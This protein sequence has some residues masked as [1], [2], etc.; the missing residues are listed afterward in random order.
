MGTLAFWH[1]RSTSSTLNPLQVGELNAAVPLYVSELRRDI[2]IFHSVILLLQCMERSFL[3]ISCSSM[4]GML[5]E[6]PFLVQIRSTF[7]VNH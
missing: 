3:F 7:F 4:F 2:R 5:H 6:L 1:V